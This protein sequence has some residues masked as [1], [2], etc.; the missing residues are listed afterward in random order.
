MRPRPGDLIGGKYRIVRL[1][2]D[3]GMGAVYEARH[4]VL[5][6][7][8]ALKFLHAELAKRPG[9]SS[10]FLQEARVSAS[11]QSPHVTRVTDVDTTHDGSPFLVMELLSGES[12]Q[13]LLDRKTK[14]AAAQAVDFT[15][16]TLSGLEAAHA[17]GVVHRDLKPDN[18]FITLSTGGPIVKLLD[19]G[20]AKLRQT[21]EYQKGLTRPGA[22]MG[23]PEY[24]APE[25]LYAAD[26]VDHRADLYSLGAILY[27]MLVGQRPADGDDAQQIIAQVLEAKIKRITEH[28]GTI[29]SGLADVVHKA[30]ASDKQERFE[31]AHA[32]RVALAP[33]AGELSHAGRLAATPAPAAALPSPEPDAEPPPEPPR[34]TEDA[35]ARRPAFHTRRARAHD[36]RHAGRHGAGRNARGAARFGDAARGA[37]GGRAAAREHAGS[38]THGVRSAAHTL[39]R[40]SRSLVFTS[41]ARTATETAARIRRRARAAARRAHHRGRHRARRCWTPIVGA[42]ERRDASEH[43]STRHHDRAA[44]RARHA[45]AG[46]AA[47]AFSDSAA[48]RRTPS[49]TRPAAASGRRCSRRRR[50]GARRCRRLPLRHSQPPHAVRVSHRISNGVAPVSRHD[51]TAT[52]KTALGMTRHSAETFSKMHRHPKKLSSPR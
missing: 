1:I 43:W 52:A 16:Q 28:D 20:I 29:P 15:L 46:R 31:S 33:F 7:P 21:N 3:G 8:V 9:L 27:E 34:R 49:G 23:T 44:G 18:I 26:R 24:M 11:I 36:A 25:Q 17:I 32:M 38:T 40:A 5:G 30:L 39:L 6:V 2:G 42:S 37:G 35:A 50:S 48:H 45:S 10:R 14:L 4:E 41:S 51:S 22:I 47:S 12:L 19:F 13:Q